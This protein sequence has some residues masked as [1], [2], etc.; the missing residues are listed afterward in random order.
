MNHYST[1]FWGRTHSGEKTDSLFIIFRFIAA[2]L[3]VNSPVFCCKIQFWFR[4]FSPPKQQHECAAR[5]VSAWCSRFEHMI[6]IR[7]FFLNMYICCVCI[8]VCVCLRSYAARGPELSLICTDFLSRATTILS[9][10]SVRLVV[11][12]HPASPH[13]VYLHVCVRFSHI[14][15]RRVRG[16]V[17]SLRPGAVKHTCALFVSARGCVMYS[18]ARRLT[19][20]RQCPLIHS[21]V[22]SPFYYML[23]VT[24]VSSSTCFGVLWSMRVAPV[25][26][27][28]CKTNTLSGQDREMGREAERP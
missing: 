11:C 8:C 15:S 19:T 1:A 16:G 17:F 9:P 23:Q 6:C 13:C 2:V 7:F 14:I 24:L 27:R 21:N 5:H 26:P 18:V 4:G 12:F 10:A 25:W 28:R 22:N 20:N 3:E